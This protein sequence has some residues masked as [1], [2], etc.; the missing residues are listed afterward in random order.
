[1][2]LK[3]AEAETH[4]AGSLLFGFHAN[5]FEQQEECTVPQK[6]TRSQKIT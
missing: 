3:N 4:P 5:S 2:N 6:N 1:M